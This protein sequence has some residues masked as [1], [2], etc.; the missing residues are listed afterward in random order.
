M[1]CQYTIAFIRG[2]VE[3]ILKCELMANKKGISPLVA[4]IMLIAFTM[5]IAGILASWASQF[6]TRERANLQLCVN[7]QILLEKGRY[8][9]INTTDGTLQLYARNN[10]NVPL[11]TFTV[12]VAY[13]NNY[14]SNDY[15]YNITAGGLQLISFGV[16]NDLTQVTI[17]SKECRG[18]QDLLLRYDIEGLA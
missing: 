12:I 4:V 15:D 2:Q 6:A 3:I 5:V 1:I 7:A 14:A 9:A 8:T 13:P 11:H 18:A 16:A 10:G 17:R